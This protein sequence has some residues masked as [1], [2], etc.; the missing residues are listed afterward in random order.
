MLRRQ[1]LAFIACR[2][3][4]PAP[5][6]VLN[7]NIGDVV[8]VAVD[9]GEGCRRPRQACSVEQRVNRYA[10]PMRVELRPLGDAVNIDLHAGLREGLELKPAPFDK[11]YVTVID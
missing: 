11:S 10:L 9:H 4:R 3:H 1:W 5:D 8:T 6:Q 2:D 7:W